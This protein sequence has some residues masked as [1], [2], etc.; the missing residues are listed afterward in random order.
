MMMHG[1]ANFKFIIVSVILL[2]EGQILREFVNRMLKE[3][4]GCKISG[5]LHGVGEVLAPEE[6]GPQDME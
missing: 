5:F 1:L 2:R 4:R 3:S 6:R